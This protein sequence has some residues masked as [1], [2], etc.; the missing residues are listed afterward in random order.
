[1]LR[2]LPERFPGA[3]GGTFGGPTNDV[4]TIA[5]VEGAPGA[6]QLVA[7]VQEAERRSRDRVGASFQFRIE[8]VAVSHAQLDAVREALSQELV[9]QGELS[10]L[11]M[12]G[13]GL[14]RS[15][16]SIRTR[17][18]AASPVERAV[19]ARYPHIPFDVQ[20]GTAPR[21]R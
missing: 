18:G 14:G 21:L 20:E 6:E 8:T 15:R 11:G 1:M 4:M 3:F 7:T 5:V 9:S 2:S 17:L 12:I 10:Q 16:V 19:R 13:V